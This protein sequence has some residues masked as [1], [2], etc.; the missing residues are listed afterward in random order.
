MSVFPNTYAW[1]QQ[2]RNKIKKQTKKVRSEAG[3]QKEAKQAQKKKEI[4]MAYHILIEI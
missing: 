2:E 4:L 3:V 1:E